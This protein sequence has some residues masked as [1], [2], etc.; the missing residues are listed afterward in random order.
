MDQAIEYLQGFREVVTAEDVR[1]SGAWASTTQRRYASPKQSGTGEGPYIETI[2]WRWDGTFESASA[3]A[4][5]ALLLVDRRFYWVKSQPPL[6]RP[7]VSFSAHGWA[8][9]S[10]SVSVTGSFHGGF[11]PSVPVEISNEPS[12]SCV[13]GQTTASTG[14]PHVVAR[15]EGVAF[16]VLLLPAPAVKVGRKRLWH[17]RED[18]ASRLTPELHRLATRGRSGEHAFVSTGQ[19]V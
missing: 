10:G 16:V 2:D 14:T 3:L 19:T 6:A 5:L 12:A 11:L 15:V 13:I 4:G 1:M 18:L 8:A 9:R 7:A 17:L